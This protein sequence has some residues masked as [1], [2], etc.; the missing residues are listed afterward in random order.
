MIPPLK[1]ASTAT[2][3]VVPSPIDLGNEPVDVTGTE[4]TLAVV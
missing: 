2:V 4:F 1:V 3:R